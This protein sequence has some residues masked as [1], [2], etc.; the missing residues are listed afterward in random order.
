MCIA[1]FISTLLLMDNSNKN[2]YLKSKTFLV[3]ELMTTK[4]IQVIGILD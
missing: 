1:D 2:Q 4:T 3:V